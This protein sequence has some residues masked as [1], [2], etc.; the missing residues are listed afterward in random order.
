MIADERCPRLT[1]QYFVEFDP[2]DLQLALSPGGPRYSTSGRYEW[3]LVDAL[4]Y[5]HALTYPFPALSS[6]GWHFT[7]QY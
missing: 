6:A 5:G 4:G 7:H 2:G 3:V 1:T